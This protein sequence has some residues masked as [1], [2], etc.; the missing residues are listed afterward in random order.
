MRHTGNSLFPDG[1]PYQI[2]TSPLNCSTNQSTGFYI[3]GTS[4]MKEFM[5]LRRLTVVML[6]Y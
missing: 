3:I 5:S 4:V 1:S 6:E 2:E